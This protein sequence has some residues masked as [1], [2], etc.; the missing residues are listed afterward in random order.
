[1]PDLDDVAYQTLELLES[2][3]RRVAFVLDGGLQQDESK[4]KRALSV[5]E[6]IQKLEDALQNLSSKTALISEVQRLKSRYPQLTD[7]SPAKGVSLDPGPAEQLAMI[8]TEAPSF[9]TT[10]S[11]LNSLHDLP[12]P[13][14]E[15]FAVLAALQPR[16]VEAE[17]RQLAQAV[18]ISELRKRNG[19]LIL[20]WH[21]VFILGQ[22]RCWAEWDTRVR[23]AEQLVRR[24]EIRISKENEA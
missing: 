19:A 15:N 22:G 11:Q 9:P 1:M 21:E 20:R 7:P 4:Q 8:L 10:A 2:R 13:P 23:K 16:I 3:L 5:P 12:V 24:R 17:R 14:T 18:E 6:R